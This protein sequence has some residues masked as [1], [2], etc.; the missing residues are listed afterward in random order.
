MASTT[1]PGARA[2]G[3]GAGGIFPLRAGSASAAWRHIDLAL[4]AATLGI[5]AMGLLMIY[6][7]TGSKLREA[8]LD[9]YMYLKRQSVWVVLGLIVMA[10]VVSVDYRVVRD[11]APFIFGGTF[12]LLILVLS[13][14]G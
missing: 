6:S 9:P 14:L 8:G 10:V 4:L 7:A 5:A 2:G 1:V 11:V 13:P 3:G 12:L